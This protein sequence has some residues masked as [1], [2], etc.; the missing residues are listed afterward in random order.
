MLTKALPT[1]L[2]SFPDRIL[3]FELSSS[4]LTQNLAC[5][6]LQSKLILG[7]VKFPVKFPSKNHVATKTM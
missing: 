4:E 5:I 7:I 6:A 1:H 2:I 3:C